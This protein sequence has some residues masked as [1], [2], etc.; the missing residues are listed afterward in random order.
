MPSDKQR[1]DELEV[2]LLAL[3][4]YTPNWQQLRSLPSYWKAGSST[5]KGDKKR[6]KPLM[7]A[8]NKQ[9]TKSKQQRYA[10]RY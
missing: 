2:I 5:L 8:S 1:A 6:P 3:G 10:R 7:R 9:G 4:P